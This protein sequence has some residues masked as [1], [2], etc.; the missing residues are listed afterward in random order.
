MIGGTLSWPATSRL[1]SVSRLSTTTA[2][3]ALVLV[4]R[5]ALVVAVAVVVAA[6]AAAAA[7]Q[8]VAAAAGVVMGVGAALPPRRAALGLLVLSYCSV[9]LVAGVVLLLH[10]LASPTP[11]SA[12]LLTPLPP[13]LLSLVWDARADVLGT[14]PLAQPSAW[15]VRGSPGAGRSPW[16]AGVFD[17]PVAVPLGIHTGVSLSQVGL[18]ASPPCVVGRAANNCTTCFSGSNTNVMLSQ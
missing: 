3:L 5:V 6:V 8:L 7:T 10:R 2:L 1:S 16:V 11:L 4:T 13:C 12:P 9:A 14:C 18:H 17:D 15:S